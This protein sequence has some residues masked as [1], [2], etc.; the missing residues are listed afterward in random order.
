QQ[1]LGT[2]ESLQRFCKEALER[3]N[4][5]LTPARQGFV[6]NFASLPSSL[7]SRLDDA[8]VSHRLRV[9]FSFPPS[10]GCEYL[11]RSHPL[12]VALAEYLLGQALGERTRDAVGTDAAVVARAGAW[13][14]AGVSE[15]TW[16]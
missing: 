12:P 16:V 2:P 11:H 13:V 4:A 15:P 9:D 8:G 10:A 14:T 1:L 6:A 7:R 5:P 3:L